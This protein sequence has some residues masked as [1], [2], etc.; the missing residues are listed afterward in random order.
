M[1][2]EGEVGEV[3]VIDVWE[4]KGDVF[5]ERRRSMGTEA[6]LRRRRS[7]AYSSTFTMGEWFEKEIV[8]MKMK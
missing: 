7:L 1:E 2:A 5:C 6:S 8:V 4:D 3:V